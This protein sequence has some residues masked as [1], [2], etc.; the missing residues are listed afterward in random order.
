MAG[1]EGWEKGRVFQAEGTAYVKAG[2]RNEK[3]LPLTGG[4]AV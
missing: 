3:L 2:W 1:E 4:K